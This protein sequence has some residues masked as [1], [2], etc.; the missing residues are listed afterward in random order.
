[1]LSIFSPDSRFMRVMSRAA[2]LILLNLC[3]LLTCLPL[4]TIGAASA[5]LYAVCFRFG[6]AE[7]QGAVRGYFRAF[8]ENLRRGTGLWLVLLLC[9]GTAAFNAWVIFAM[10][11]PARFLAVLFAILLVLAVLIYGYAFPLLSQ[12]DDGV[13]HTLRNALI[14]S[15]GYLP[16]SLLIA[17]VNAFPFL[18]LVRDPYGFLQAAFLW[19]ALYFALAAYVNTFLL[20]RVLAPYLTDENTEEE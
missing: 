18:M 7:E 13:W 14:L 11:G 10:P 8:R 12:F 20:R 5:A 3:Y 4:F 19:T 2:D 1:M 15:L 16:R 9:G 17:A 6:T